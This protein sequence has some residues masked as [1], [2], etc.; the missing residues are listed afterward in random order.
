MDKQFVLITTI[1]NLFCSIVHHLNGT[2]VMFLAKY[3]VCEKT[4]AAILFWFG[5]LSTSK[6]GV[7]VLQN[8]DK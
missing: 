3:E 2:L 5:A 7:L 6:Y 4:V 1:R 8:D